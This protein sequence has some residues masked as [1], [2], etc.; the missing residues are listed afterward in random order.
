MTMKLVYKHS[1]RTQSIS[2]DLKGSLKRRSI[3]LAMEQKP[4]KQRTPFDL[5]FPESNP[6]QA[7]PSRKSVRIELDDGEILIDSERVD[8][9]EELQEYCL[10]M[11][12]LTFGYK[13][14]DIKKVPAS[15]T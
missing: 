3:H 6:L 5:L 7:R 8:I 12:K 10:L 1:C 9:L 14:Q 15:T 13:L 4:Q 11:T 2:E